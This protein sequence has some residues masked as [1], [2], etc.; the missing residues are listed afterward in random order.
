MDGRF[1]VAAG[2]NRIEAIGTEFTV[3]NRGGKTL[4]WVSEGAVQLITGCALDDAPTPALYSGDQAL[5]ANVGCPRRPVLSRL[6]KE[7]MAR[8]HAWLQGGLTFDR[9]S[10]ASAV[11]EI[12]RYNQRQIVLVDPELAGKAIGGHFSATDPENFVKALEEMKLVRVERLPDPPG[13]L[14]EIRL[15]QP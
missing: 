12:N 8:R 1:S 11:A 2:D 9:V 10:L 4:V 15:H 13:G 3:Q 7:E 5:I 6:T 14:A